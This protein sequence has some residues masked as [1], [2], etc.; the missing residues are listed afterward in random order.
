[1]EGRPE[2]AKIFLC[3]DRSVIGNDGGKKESGRSI[4]IFS[5]QLSPRPVELA[6]YMVMS[7]TVSGSELRQDFRMR[8]D[9]SLEWR[10]F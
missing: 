8:T 3:G 10:H 5:L 2:V 6:I 4:L 7:T 1:L 9:H